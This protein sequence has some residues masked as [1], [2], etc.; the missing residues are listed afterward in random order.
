MGSGKNTKIIKNGLLW[1]F[2]L[3][4]MS[5]QAE[6]VAQFSSFFDSNL[7]TSQHDEEHPGPSVIILDRGDVL[8]SMR[9]PSLDTHITLPQE[10]SFSRIEFPF[11]YSVNHN[12]IIKSDCPMHGSLVPRSHLQQ[13]TCCL[14]PV[15]AIWGSRVL[16]LVRIRFEIQIGVLVVRNLGRRR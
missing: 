15:R 2:R 10:S 13:S 9:R 12:A 6:S 5:R 7:F 16:E 1:T 8:P 3:I 4:S 14:S 11:D